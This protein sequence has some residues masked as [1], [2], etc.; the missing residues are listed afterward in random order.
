MIYSDIKYP[1][2][3][4]GVHLLTNTVSMP[5]FIRYSCSLAGRLVSEIMVSTPSSGQV[6]L[7]QL[8]PNFLEWATN[9]DFLAWRMMC[10]LSLATSRL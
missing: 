9:T 1:V 4:R 6:T 2:L 5:C 10:S 7:M 8:I 3:E